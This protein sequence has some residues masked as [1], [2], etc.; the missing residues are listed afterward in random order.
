ISDAM[1]LLETTRQAFNATD[2]HNRGLYFSQVLAGHGWKFTELGLSATVLPAPTGPDHP[3]YSQY[4][5]GV[6]V[7]GLMEFLDAAH[8][9]LKSPI[10]VPLFTWSRSFG[11]RIAAHYATEMLNTQVGPEH[12]P[13]LQDFEGVSQVAGYAW[14]FVQHAAA[15]P[16]TK[17][18]AR[19]PYT[20]ETIVMLTKNWLPAANRNY[21]HQLL[22]QLNP[23]VRAFLRRNFRPITEAFAVQFFEFIASQGYPEDL[24][25]S[26]LDLLDEEFKNE[27]AWE[28]V[29]LRDYLRY[30]MTGNTRNNLVV[31]PGMHGMSRDYLDMDHAG[32]SIPLALLELRYVG[33]P[34]GRSRVHSHEF[35]R[36]FSEYAKVVNLGHSSAMRQRISPGVA[37]VI[38]GDDRVQKF[39]RAIGAIQKLP[40]LRLPGNKYL[41]HFPY[42]VTTS[43]ADSISRLARGQGLNAGDRSEFGD[44][45]AN[46]RAVHDLPAV[47]SE[48]KRQFDSAILLMESAL[49]SLPPQTV[50]PGGYRQ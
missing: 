43:V 30:T 45:L 36:Q 33:G 42:L 18:G 14:L 49:S 3:A 47:S 21:F 29:R 1:R 9:R 17:A 48:V 37:Q 20:G 12:V 40:R 35:L 31:S 34:S 27:V 6:P 15:I 38:L 4:T 2:Q 41:R 28:A 7:S 5:F 10:A 11:Q 8:A 22:Q 24:F 26:H 50:P 46:L 23:E 19:D 32:R 13:F 39:S 44:L 25:N 16:M